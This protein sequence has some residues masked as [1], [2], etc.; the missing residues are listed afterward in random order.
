MLSNRFV[1][2]LDIYVNEVRKGEDGVPVNTMIHTY[3]GIQDPGAAS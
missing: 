2:M 1:A 3:R